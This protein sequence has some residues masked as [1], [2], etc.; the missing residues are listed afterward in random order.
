MSREYA[1][2]GM[3]LARGQTKGNTLVGYAS[4]KHFPIETLETLLSGTI[5]Y[6]RDGAFTKTLKDNAPKE[7][8]GPWG[9]IQSL[10][11]HG[12]DPRYGELPIGRIVEMREDAHGLYTE[13]ELHDGPDNEN[14][15]AALRSGALRSMSIA[16]EAVKDSYSDDRSTRDI[17][18]IR[19]FEF[20]PV[21]FPAN[22]AATAALHSMSALIADDQTGADS[23]AGEAEPTPSAGAG[24]TS[25]EVAAATPLDAEKARVVLLER[26]LQ[27]EY[28][29]I[30]RWAPRTS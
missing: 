25:I 3:E 20:G 11:N 4:V 2:F 28:E 13:V 19:L 17:T 5:T 16:F 23:T 27:A 29:R 10:F 15:K 8:G 1:S 24:S 30:Q 26:E 18:E 6:I 9:E 14:I 22:A 21:T 7:P 12:R